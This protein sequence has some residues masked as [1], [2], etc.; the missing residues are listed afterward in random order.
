[1]YALKFFPQASWHIMFGSTTT[2]AS[3]T[4]EPTTSILHTMDSDNSDIEEAP[5][6]STPRGIVREYHDDEPESPAV[7]PLT[8]IYADGD[9]IINISLSYPFMNREGWGDRS[10]EPFLRVKVSST[11]LSVASLELEKTFQALKTLTPCSDEYVKQTRGVQWYLK[12]KKPGYILADLFICISWDDLPQGPPEIKPEDFS[13]LFQVLHFQNPEILEG[14]GSVSGPGYYHRRIAR[15]SELAWVFGCETGVR[16][17]VQSRR[18]EYD[19]QKRGANISQQVPGEGI[20][21]P[22]E[23]AIEMAFVWGDPVLFKI[24][25]RQFVVE[26]DWVDAGYRWDVYKGMGIFPL[27]QGAFILAFYIYNTTDRIEREYKTENLICYIFEP[28]RFSP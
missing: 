6:R 24:S 23:G 25:T 15:I 20:P 14:A 28:T 22:S 13:T 1:M 21:T 12:V 26:S 27:L 5:R 17:W 19:L 8:E 7:L 4:E 9:M 3:Q 11:V 2:A 18:Q 10:I 16:S